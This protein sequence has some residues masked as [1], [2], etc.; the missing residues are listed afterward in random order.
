MQRKVLLALTMAVF[1]LSFLL[2]GCQSGI[3]PEQYE[4]IAHQLVK[5]KEEITRLQDEAQDLLAQ[6]QAVEA[7][8]QIAQVKISELQAQVGGL[9]EQY[10]LVG[11][12][13]ADTA[14]NIVRYYHETHVYSTYDYYVCSDMASDVWNMLKA[15]GI[16]A[17]IVV[18]DTEK[19][20]GDIVQSNHAWVLAEVAP[21]QYLALA[22]TGGFVVPKNE[23]ALYYQGWSFDTPKELKR[24][25]E[26]IREY[27]IRV[28]IHNEI[29]A[30]DREVVDEHNQATSQ[31][32]AGRLKAVHDKLMELI[33]QQETE[34]NN[35][36][37][38]ITGLATQL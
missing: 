23:N 37:S 31:S 24:Y 11:E 34:L 22:T 10:E 19:A 35:I 20:I 16:G 21:G 32:T 12:T 27:N 5:A 36:K 14:R 6:K 29:A 33:E 9:K 15:Q 3:S 30:E 1:L 13:P 26:L 8:L 18:G 38:E 2:A 7:D 17:I 25:N 28:C 4:G